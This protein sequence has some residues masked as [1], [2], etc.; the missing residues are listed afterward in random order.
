MIKLCKNNKTKHFSVHRLIAQTFIPNPENKPQV[1]HKDGNKLNNCVE[2]L[3]WVTGKENI[4]HAI[5]NSLID[6]ETRKEKMKKIGKTQNGKNN[7]SWRGYINVF[8]VNKKLIKQF[9][10]L[11]EIKEWLQS[12]TKYKISVGNI[13]TAIKKQNVIYGYRYSYDNAEG[14]RNGGFRKHWEIKLDIFSKL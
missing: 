14:E 12:R 13:C 6:I 7:N 2:N 11:S 9:E 8:D 10:T 1:N 3:E 5:Q 4:K